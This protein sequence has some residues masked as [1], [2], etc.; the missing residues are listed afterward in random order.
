MIELANGNVSTDSLDIGFYGQY[1]ATGAK[2]TGL[3]RDATDGLF[4]LFTGSE[5]EPTTTVD[6]AATGYGIATL[7]SYLTSGGFVSNGTNI[8]IT[9]N[10]TLAVAIVANT[11]SLSTALPATSGG[12]GFAT[13]TSGEILVANTGN[14]LSKLSL[15]ADGKVL[16]S[17]GTALIYDDL[18]GGTF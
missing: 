5:V 2:F 1:G 16:Q 8:A 12:T 4:K 11:L 6:T 18:D 14:A 10:S 9:A 3:F 15:G 7:N 17:N 13:Y